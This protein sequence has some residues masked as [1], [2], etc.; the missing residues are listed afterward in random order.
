M[1]K[2]YHRVLFGVVVSFLVAGLQTALPAVNGSVGLDANS[3]HVWR[4]ITLT[5]GIVL[6][7]HFNVK[8]GGFTFAYWGNMNVEDYDKIKDQ[9]MFTESDVSMSYEYDIDTAVLGIGYME[10]YYSVGRE[11]TREVFG[12][13][14]GPIF[15]D[16]LF[17]GLKVYY[18]FGAIRDFYANATINYIFK[19]VD[20]LKGD[21]GGSVGY[22][23]K[24]MSAGGH[25]GLDDYMLFFGVNYDVDSDLAIGGKLAYVDTLSEKVLPDQPVHFFLGL[26]ITR[27][28]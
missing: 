13:V 25:S 1:N 15:M 4:G 12:S 21:V 20:A 10:Y 11:D 7:P 2:C 14:R 3:A 26:S 16:N 23:G 17:A 19:M 9:G 28:F 6:D 27:K 18:D 22:A 5:D 8:L 24:D